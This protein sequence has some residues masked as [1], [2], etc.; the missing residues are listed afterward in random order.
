MHQGGSAGAGSTAVE[1]HLCWGA[2]QLLGWCMHQGGS[3]D[4]ATAVEL[5]LCWGAAQ[6]LGWCMQQ[7]GSAA[8]TT[9]VELHCC[10]GAGQLLGW[11]M[12]QGRSA[13]AGMQGGLDRET[14][15]SARMQRAV[16][17][18]IEESAGAG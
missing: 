7:G 11:C 10:W 8:G 13:A 3:A 17:G 12:Q 5:H 14:A 4:E 2:A 9:A 18:R 15:H 1:L 6:L 16:S